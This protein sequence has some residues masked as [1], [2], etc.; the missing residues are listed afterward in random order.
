MVDF[1][2]RSE[3]RSRT[4]TCA[5]VREHDPDLCAR[6]AEERVTWLAYSPTNSDDALPRPGF[7]STAVYFEWL[8]QKEMRDDD[9]RQRLPKVAG[10]YRSLQRCFPPDGSPV[11]ARCRIRWVTAPSPLPLRASLRALLGS[12]TPFMSFRPKREPRSA[13]DATGGVLGNPH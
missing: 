13:C 10:F 1:S 9:Q 3:P 11:A 4:R 8:A 7:E 12:S 6:R 5:H 2:F